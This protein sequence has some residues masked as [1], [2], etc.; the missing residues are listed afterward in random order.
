MSAIIQFLKL[1]NEHKEKIIFGALVVA[2][3]VVGAVLLREKEDSGGEKPPVA[4]GG[5]KTPP[6]EAKTY[7]SVRLGNHHTLETLMEQAA[8]GIFAP[9]EPGTDGS[10]EKEN[11]WAEIKVKSIFDATGSGS[12]VA[13]IEV[14]KKRDFVREG[15]R[16]GEYS[17]RRIDGVKKCLIIVR[18]GSQEEDEEKKFCTED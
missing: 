8:P 14:D 12:F 18:R 17:V 9:S 11:I 15:E 3:I 13:I 2:F 4:G 10:D 1:L 16:F 5:R 6:R 7:P